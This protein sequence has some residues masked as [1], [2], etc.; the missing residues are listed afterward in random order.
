MWI[1]TN[2]GF[3]SIVAKDAAGKPSGK[4]MDA[5]VSVRFRRKEDA[6][7]LFPGHTYVPT[8]GGDYAG[9]VFATR[10]EVA[11]VLFDE[12]SGIDYSN[13]K[14]S[15]PAKDKALKDACMSAW[16][17]FGRLQPGGPYGRSAF[18]DHRQPSIFDDWRDSRSPRSVSASLP[19]VHG[20]PKGRGR[21]RELF[22]TRTC[23]DCGMTH[24]R[25]EI[26]EAGRCGDC[27]TYVASLPGDPLVDEDDAGETT[28]WSC[29]GEE[30]VSGEH[31]LCA[32]CEGYYEGLSDDDIAE[33]RA[34]VESAEGLFAGLD[35][36][37]ARGGK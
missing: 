22:G 12:A 16:S 2:K 4:F 21:K 34:S 3:M 23:A 30:D 31:D 8:P 25:D 5:I 10:S 1:V 20:V 18:T 27:A 32:A 37:I 11:Q 15:I 29:G 17:V 9:R 14:D 36:T 19:V 6:A 35:A 26:D 33:I 28:C 13:F 24:D 7:A